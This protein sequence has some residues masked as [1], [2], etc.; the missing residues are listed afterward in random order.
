M[1][2]FSAIAT[3]ITLKP[4]PQ[5]PFQEITANFCSHAGQQYL[6][7]V[8]YFSDWLEITPMM[9]NTTTKKLVSALKS[10]FCRTGDPD[11]VWTD[12]GQQFTSQSL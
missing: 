11:K 3:N 1:S 9:T 7:T 12:Q 6:L 2:R 8:D 10:S 5:R 4:T